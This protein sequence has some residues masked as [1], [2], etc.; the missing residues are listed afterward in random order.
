MSSE[1]LHGP[2]L[3]GKDVTDN[4][5]LCALAESE[6]P[7]SFLL[8]RHE[9]LR[10]LPMLTSD[11]LASST[12]EE[13]V[14]SLRNVLKKDEIEFGEPDLPACLKDPVSGEPLFFP[15]T[16]RAENR[17]DQTTTLDFS[18]RRQL[19]RS[20]DNLHTDPFTRCSLMTCED[21]TQRYFFNRAV[22]EASEWATKMF[23]LPRPLP[24]DFSWPQEAFTNLSIPRVKYVGDQ[25][26]PPSVYVSEDGFL[27]HT[28]LRLPYICSEE[29]LNG[30]SASIL[31]LDALCAGLLFVVTRFGKK[32]C[33]VLPAGSALDLFGEPP[34]DLGEVLIDDA[35]FP[36]ANV[37]ILKASAKAFTGDL[38]HY[39]TDDLL[40]NETL[41]IGV[42]EP[43]S[44]EAAQAVLKRSRKRARTVSD[45]KRVQCNVLVTHDVPPGNSI[46]VPTGLSSRWQKVH[47]PFNFAVQP[48]VK[49]DVPP[50]DSVIR[51]TEAIRNGVR[52]FNHSLISDFSRRR[53]VGDTPESRWIEQLQTRFCIDPIDILF[54]LRSSSDPVATR[55]VTTYLTPTITSSLKYID[56]LI[57]NPRATPAFFESNQ[58]AISAQLGE[59]PFVIM[60]WTEERHGFN[61]ILPI[62][63]LA[64]HTMPSCFGEFSSSWLHTVMAFNGIQDLITVRW[65]PDVWEKIETELVGFHEDGQPPRNCDFYY[66]PDDGFFPAF[67]CEEEP[68]ILN[69]PPYVAPIELNA[70]QSS[71][72]ASS[73]SSSNS[74]EEDS[75]DGTHISISDDDEFDEPPSGLPFFVPISLPFEIIEI[76]NVTVV[77]PTSSTPIDGLQDFRSNFTA[78]CFVHR[79]AWMPRGSTFPTMHE[80]WNSLSDDHKVRYRDFVN[81]IRRQ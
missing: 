33:M 81:R 4:D 29:L 46:A 49:I 25:R 54:N 30:V 27:R 8:L 2:S 38:L 19:I 26:L 57:N 17:L 28:E 78:F 77:I 32:H 18:S 12:K 61:L 11:V 68:L 58:W 63:G 37:K 65:T 35:V 71:E 75:S 74:S 79:L 55:G 23:G 14:R 20:G 40:H 24:N 15:I 16:L 60:K 42:N 31:P 56:Y 76:R 41:G 48:L 6:A 36:P 51:R 69:A 59:A 22:A 64:S 10:C 53:V 13:L 7:E 52:V 62:F 72:I 73:I 3:Y 5:R 44:V 66:V 70:D 34:S 1:L 45:S 80:I 67:F 50:P 43:A 39:R 21:R 47:W 9:M